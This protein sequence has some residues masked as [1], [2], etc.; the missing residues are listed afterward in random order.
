MYKQ[1]H[2]VYR[3]YL[4]CI[5]IVSCR[6]L[7]SNLIITTNN[8][9]INNPSNHTFKIYY[10]NSIAR[11]SFTLYFPSCDNLVNSSVTNTNGTILSITNIVNNINNINTNIS[12]I[13]FNLP[14][15]ISSTLYIFNVNNIMNC[16]HAGNFKN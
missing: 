10:T 16:Y 2:N 13:S 14:T 1:S 6:S 7:L 12:S 4:I 9:Q 8:T 3:I 11:S 5:I 15:S